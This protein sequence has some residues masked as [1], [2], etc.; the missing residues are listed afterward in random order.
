MN[1]KEAAEI[2]NVSQ[3]DG[4]AVWTHALKFAATA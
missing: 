4:A 1:I 2:L 3:D